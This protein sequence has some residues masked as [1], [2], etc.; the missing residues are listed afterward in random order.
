M[1]SA[2]RKSKV[3]ATPDISPKGNKLEE[4]KL[5]K[6]EKCSALELLT[7]LIVNQP[8]GSECERFSS[9][10]SVPRFN[11]Q[12]SNSLFMEEGVAI[13]LLM[14]EQWEVRKCANWLLIFERVTLPKSSP[15]I[16]TL[17]FFTGTRHLIAQLASDF[18]QYNV[19]TELSGWIESSLVRLLI[20][21]GNLCISAILS[22]MVEDVAEMADRYGGRGANGGSR[23]NQVPPSP[24]VE[25]KVENVFADLLHEVK[26]ASAIV[27]P[28]AGA[29]FKIDSSLYQLL[30]LEGYFQNSTNDD[31]HQHL[32]NVLGVCQTH[33]H[34]V[35][36]LDALQLRI[37]K[38]SLAGE[39]RA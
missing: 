23:G 29:N 22:S 9:C 2:K 18:A 35:T 5:L 37:F 14:L 39:A 33:T 4:V 12:Q 6:V 17:D 24:E 28:R 13:L 3:V 15:L 11:K 7:E 30:K 34:N 21:K 32:R 19:V 8:F 26:Y 20:R 27:P 1:G 16:K 38:Y 36:Y 31:P 10:N 25:N